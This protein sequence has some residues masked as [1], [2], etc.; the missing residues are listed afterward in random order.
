VLFK[1]RTVFITGASRGIG[2]AVALRLA[3]EGANIALLSKTETPNPDLP[4]TVHS[5]AAEIETAGGFALPLAV[6]IR[7]ENAVQDAAEKT[8]TRFGGIDI[9]I[10]NAS[11]I[12]FAGT[13][14]TP[15][16]KYDLMMDVNARGTFI[17]VKTCLP[18]LLKSTNAQILTMSPPLNIGTKWLGVSPAYTLSKFGMSL[19]TIGFAG[20]FEGKIRANTLWPKTFIATDAIRVNFGSMISHS[21][22]TAIVA[23]AAHAILSNKI[24]A[25][26]GQHLVDEAVLRRIGVTD[27]SS[28]AT[29]P[30]N[31]PQ[32]DIFLDGW[33]GQS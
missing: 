29:D 33:D 21:R 11:A 23:D 12:H 5:V 14:E 9:V 15:T 30:A 13:D 4:G 20:E 22:S 19:L 27:F 31:Q 6:D 2:R 32:D 10:N 28:Y 8:A 16:K 25:V 17:C 26:T 7:D 18:W 24:G 1:G 3:A